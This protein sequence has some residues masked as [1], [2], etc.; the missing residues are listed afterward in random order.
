MLLL[1]LLQVNV[2]LAFA[3]FRRSDAGKPF[4]QADTRPAVWCRRSVHALL[5]YIADADITN[6][7]LEQQQQQQQQMVLPR[8]EYLYSRSRPY[9][10]LD[11]Y[12]FL[13]DRLRACWQELTVQHVS[14][15]RASIETLEISFRFL[16]LS[17]EI[18]AG[19]PGFD[20]VSNHG[21]MQTCLDKLMQG[22]EATRAFH[23]KRDAVAAAAAAATAAAPSSS[24]SNS[25]KGGE[26]MLLDLLVY[27]SPYEGEFW[28]FRLLML[29]AQEASDT[30]LVSLLQRL[31]QPLQQDPA[32]RFA[33]AAYRSFKDLDLRRYVKLMRKGPYLLCLLLHKFLPYARARLLAA[34]VLSRLAGGNRNPISSQRLSVLL[35]FD[36]EKG[37]SERE[38]QSCLSLS[39]SWCFSLSQP[40]FS[41]LSLTPTHL[42]SLSLCLCLLFDCPYIM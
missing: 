9:T 38:R 26:G 21:L 2:H 13:R 30:A 23:S 22:Y 10:Y 3:S 25:S 41:S 27:S 33:L 11:V 8:K 16:V 19:T 40:S 28:G 32:V 29:L 20:A 12:N 4:K 1:L 34:L 42:P 36:G 37:E 24:S 39:V 5:A 14:P 18:L 7:A 6:G 15:H 31:P 17:E 35:G